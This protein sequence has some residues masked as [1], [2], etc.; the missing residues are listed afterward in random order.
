MELYNIWFESFL[1]IFFAG[2]YLL[3]ERLLEKMIE[4]AAKTGIE[5][6][7]I[8]VS[9]VV[10]GWVKKDGLSFRQMLNPNRYANPF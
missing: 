7:I 2:H 6:R 5:G 9:S 10:H 8:N 3:T 4:T 1:F